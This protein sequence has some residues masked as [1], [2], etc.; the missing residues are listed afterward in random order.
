MRGCKRSFYKRPKQF[1]EITINIE[2]RKRE[3]IDA[4]QLSVPLQ[5]SNLPDI[6]QC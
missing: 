4:D 6:S 3:T 2:Q 5:R 1:C